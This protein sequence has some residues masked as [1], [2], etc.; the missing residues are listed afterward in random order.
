MSTRP[1]LRDVWRVGLSMAAGALLASGSARTTLAQQAVASEAVGAAHAAAS[2]DRKGGG[3]QG[4]RLKMAPAKAEPIVHGGANIIDHNAIG[5]SVVRPD[6]GQK[7]TGL[8]LGR[9]GTPAAPVP[10]IPPAPPGG[11]VGLSTRPLLAPHISAPAPRPLVL[12]RGTINGAAFTRPGTALMP[13]GGPAKHA[14]VGI[15]GT[16][17]QPKH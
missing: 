8:N 17:I 16:S 14:S 7:P 2:G 6:S 11:A 3:G 4:A 9:A 1:L 12:S 13:L 10:P 5:I 15:N